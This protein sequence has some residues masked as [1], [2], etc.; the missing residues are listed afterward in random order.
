VKLADGD[1]LLEFPSS[2][3]KTYTVVYS[4]DVRFTNAMIA[5]PIIV[6]TATNRTQWLDYGPPATRSA[7][8]NSSQ[9]F[10][11]VLLNP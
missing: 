6:P 10:Y 3:T 5:L 1:L 4:D 2:M 8:T 7:P 9:R 11:R